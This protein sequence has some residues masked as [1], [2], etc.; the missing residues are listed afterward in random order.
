M[1]SPGSLA[2]IGMLGRE[3]V[4][5]H[6]GG[7]FLSELDNEAGLSNVSLP[8]PSS[9]LTL[10]SKGFSQAGLSDNSNL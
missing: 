9:L 2:V 8:H 1:N 7:G 10:F 5:S 4:D 3:W 6:C